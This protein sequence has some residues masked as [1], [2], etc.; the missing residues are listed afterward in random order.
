MKTIF[1]VIFEE[2]M[3]IEGGY[4]EDP[5]GGPTKYGV[6]L[7]AHREEIGDRDK[8]GDVDGDDVKLL[9]MQDAEPIFR[10]HYWAPVWGNELPP[11]LAMQ[12]ADM[13]YHHGVTRAVRL[14][15]AA[16]AEIGYPT[17]VIDGK[18]GYRTLGALRKAFQEDKF[19]ILA[20]IQRLRLNFMRGL[21]NWEPNKKGWERRVFRVTACSGVFLMA[22]LIP[23]F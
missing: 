13:A 21:P 7:R 16:C 5:A 9:T 1:Q 20:E 3:W 4:F 10:E 18:M 19:G 17:G 14:A 6:S 15:Q 12:L 22:G 8:D 2:I 11:A 23:G